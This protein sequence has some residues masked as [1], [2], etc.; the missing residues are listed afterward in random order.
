[1][2]FSSKAQ[3]KACFATNGFGGKVDCGEW[4]RKT[5]YSKLPDKI[6]KKKKKKKKNKFKSFKEWL[7]EKTQG[8]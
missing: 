6:A 4:S 5:D 2:P 7:E 8:S 3:M 1:M